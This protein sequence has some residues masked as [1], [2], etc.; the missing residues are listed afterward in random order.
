MH[1]Q[2][3]EPF[4]PLCRTQAGQTC[5][6]GVGCQMSRSVLRTG[7]KEANFLCRWSWAHQCRACATVT[8]STLPP[9]TPVSSALAWPYSM[10]GSR[11]ASFSCCSD[12]SSATTWA[13][14]EDAQRV[15]I[16]SYCFIKSSM[17]ACRDVSRSSMLEEH[18]LELAREH[19]CSLSTSRRNIEC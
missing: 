14:G 16:D 18:P 13:H 12:W 1:L 10:L 7:T 15:V 9:G 3:A 2:A 19:G 6:T 17:N 4:G 11:T 5:G 8:R